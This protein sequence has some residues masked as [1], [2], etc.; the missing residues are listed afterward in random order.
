MLEGKHPSRS[1]E[2]VFLIVHLSR[3]S[4]R[5]SMGL[6]SYSPGLLEGRQSQWREAAGSA[7]LPGTEKES[8]WVA[9]GEDITSNKKTADRRPWEDHVGTGVS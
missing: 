5:T 3:G 1:K 9:E 8:A 7:G 2:C 4:E 6:E